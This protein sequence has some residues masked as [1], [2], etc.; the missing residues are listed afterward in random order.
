MLAK[1]LSIIAARAKHNVYNL[2]P[3]EC[4]VSLIN[5]ALFYLKHYSWHH[6]VG[7][8]FLKEGR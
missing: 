6:Q 8:M 3:N 5:T 1:C 2:V 4:R 7:N